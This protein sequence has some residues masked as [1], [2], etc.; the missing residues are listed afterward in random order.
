MLF[1]FKYE[2]KILKLHEKGRGW[3]GPGGHNASPMSPWGSA[4]TQCGPSSLADP[5]LPPP[6]NSNFSNP[7]GTGRGEGRASPQTTLRHFSVVSPSRTQIR[8]QS[9]LECVWGKPSKPASESETGKGPGTSGG[10]SEFPRR[11]PTSLENGV[12]GMA[13]E[14]WVTRKA[15]PTGREAPGP[16]DP[17]DL[18][19]LLSL[20]DGFL[21]KW[22]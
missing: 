10:D 4:E 21:K 8:I 7:S 9:S 1:I 19:E 18:L 12:T 14:T 22:V 20:T 13:R 6:T 16:S 2:F 5:G 3:E 11:Q 15:L 17:F